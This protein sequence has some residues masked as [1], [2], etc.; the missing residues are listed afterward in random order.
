NSDY[1][2]N[3]PFVYVYSAFG[4][5]G[6]SYVVNDGFE[7]WVTIPGSFISGH[8]FNDLNS[9]GTFNAGEPLLSGWTIYIDL[10][11][12]GTFDNGDLS[13]TTDANGF[14]QF[15]PIGTGTYNIREIQ[16]TG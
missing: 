14:Y 15:G 5:Q 10:N 7:E 6:G 9:N 8:K 3:L 13:T 4:Y 2:S 11:N 1:Q 16:Q 12:N